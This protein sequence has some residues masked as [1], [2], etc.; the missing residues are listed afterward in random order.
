MGLDGSSRMCTAAG[1][2]TPL[3]FGRAICC[4]V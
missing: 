1:P 2:P 3:V 4:S